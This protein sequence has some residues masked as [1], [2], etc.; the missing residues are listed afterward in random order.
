MT[1]DDPPVRYCEDCGNEMIFLATSYHCDYCD[2]LVDEYDEDTLFG[3]GLE[4]DPGELDTQPMFPAVPSFGWNPMPP[5]SGPPKGKSGNKK[6]PKD[7]SS[8]FHNTLVDAAKN[9]PFAD[10]DIDDLD[11]DFA[12]DEDALGPDAI[13]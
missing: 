3:D 12:L 6:N 13:D 11:L 10:L 7:Q 8:S 4:W 9:N 5:T 2:G 1:Y